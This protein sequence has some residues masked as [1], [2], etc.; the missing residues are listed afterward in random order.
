[1]ARMKLVRLAAASLTLTAAFAAQL[2][3]HESPYIAKLSAGT[4]APPS[5]SLGSGSV[6]LTVNFDLFTMEIEAEFSGL[7]GN[8]VSASIHGLTSLPLEGAAATI[9]RTLPDFP[10]GVTAGSYEKTLDLTLATS[11]DP[12]F[13]ASFGG[14]ISL[15][16]NAFFEG[17]VEGTTYFNLETSAFA[18]GEIRGFLMPT[19]KSDFNRDGVVSGHDL[20]VWKESFNVDPRGDANDDDV[21]NGSDLL[22]WQRQLGALAQPRVHGGHEH[23]LAVPEPAARD[24]VTLAA[25]LSA[26]L[27][28]PRRIVRQIAKKSVACP[29]RIGHYEIA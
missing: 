10:V 19:P 23:G 25:A 12:A 21:T 8:V 22:A 27:R 14:S 2:R 9:S 7:T 18:T 26:G 1:M 15:A 28:A 4:Q 5:T 20:A 3:A 17:L 11:Y 29:R 24:L 16:S 6:A 13:L